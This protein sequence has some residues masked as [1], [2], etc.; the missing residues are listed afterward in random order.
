MRNILVVSDIDGTLM[1]H[2]YDLSAALNTIS[3]LKENRIPI[4]LCTSKTASEVRKI[5]DNIGLKDPFIVENGGAIYGNKNDSLE[6]W[7]IIL[8][9]SYSDLRIIL[10]RLSTDIGYRLK[11]LNDL[12][13]EE[14]RKLTGL[15]NPDIELALQRHWSVPFLTPS[16][17]YREKLNRNIDK[18]KINIYQG[19]LMSHLLSR[20]SHKGKAVLALKKYLGYN[21]S[22]VIALGDSQNDVPLLEIA[23]KAIVVPGKSGPN[24]LLLE[25]IKHKDF[26]IAPAPHAEGWSIAVKDLVTEKLDLINSN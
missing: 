3:L 8:G 1:D 11:A 26:I 6:E 25:G 2:N 16:K 18:Y 21:D 17:E 20:E 22:F 4:I 14:I 13:H 15:S 24:K 12:N 7:E 10:D 23:D 5:R 9:R 19:N